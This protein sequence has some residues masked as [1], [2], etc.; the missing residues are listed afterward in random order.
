MNFMAEPF[1]AD[2]YKVVVNG[3]KFF[4][5]YRWVCTAV[6][7][8]LFLAVSSLHAQ[9]CSIPGNSGAASI[10]TQ[11]NT[12]FPGTGNPA[13]GAT[14]LTVTGGTGTNSGIQAGD[15]LLIIQM[16]GADIDAT[17]TNAYGDATTNAGV[18][19][20]VAFGV[21]GY[22]GGVNGTNFVA[23]NYEWAV[24]TGGGATFAA[25][26]TINLSAPLTRS[27]FTRALAGALGKQAY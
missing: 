1:T 27:Y 5:L 10:A 17:D 13:A 21:A 4:S 9:T 22:A 7:S 15:L 24:A 2:L 26:G 20:T 12:F 11:P 16:Q 8:L 14:S 6:F 18:T 3:R 25:G 19:N 23:G